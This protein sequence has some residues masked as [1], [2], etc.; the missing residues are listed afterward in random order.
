MSPTTCIKTDLPQIILKTDHE[1]FFLDSIEYLEGNDFEIIYKTFD[2][3][4]ENI[5]NI[6]TEYEEKFYQLGNPI[7]KLIMH[8][9]NNAF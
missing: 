7:C 1:N 6:M 9:E 2:L 3:H 8:H 4:S 5:K